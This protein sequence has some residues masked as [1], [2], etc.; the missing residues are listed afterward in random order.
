MPPSLG[1]R[2]QR[3]HHGERGDDDRAEFLPERQVARL[4]DL[5]RLAVPIQFA[6]RASHAE[7][8]DLLERV[9][10]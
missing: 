5:D 6:G 4:P 3:A 2:A 8:V 7:T 1:D 10:D 9:I